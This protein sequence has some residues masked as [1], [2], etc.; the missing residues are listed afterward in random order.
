MYFMGPHIICIHKGGGTYFETYSFSRNRI[1]IT[2][3]LFGIMEL[4]VSRT[5]KD[6]SSDTI[7]HQI[8]CSS[9]KT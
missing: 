9:D 4:H 5:E 3:F 6:N 2:Y 7:E 1:L 8:P